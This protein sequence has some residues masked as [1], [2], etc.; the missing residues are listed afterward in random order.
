LREVD[1]HQESGKK[2]IPT[3]LAKCPNSPHSLRGEILNVSCVKKESDLAKAARTTTET[4][5][6]RKLKIIYVERPPRQPEDLPHG[7]A[8]VF[9]GVSGQHVGLR[10][11]RRGFIAS[12]CVIQAITERVAELAKG[13]VG[14]RRPLAERI[15]LSPML[16]ADWREFLDELL[17]RSD[18]W[19]FLAPPAASQGP[20]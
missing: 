19:A 15:G 14:N 20:N 7:I 10:I 5:V 17:Q 4:E 11:A 16:S 3:E 8:E 2:N 12:D 18:S 13:A 1:I 6:V 9:I